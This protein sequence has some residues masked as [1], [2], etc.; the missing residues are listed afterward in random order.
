MRISKRQALSNYHSNF[1]MQLHFDSLVV[2]RE[3]RGPARLISTRSPARE[4]GSVDA[5]ENSRFA[6]DYSIAS[7]GRTRTRFT[8]S[9]FQNP[10]YDS[11][12]KTI[13]LPLSVVLHCSDFLPLSRRTPLPAAGR[14]RGRWLLRAHP[15]QETEPTATS[16]HAVF[17]SARLNPKSLKNVW[18]LTRQPHVV[19]DCRNQTAPLHDYKERISFSEAGNRTIEAAAMASSG[20]RR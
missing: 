13:F 12:S 15:H 2:W 5:A 11:E 4:L 8:P 19:C 3:N 20:G 7:I 16:N 14:W 9:I 6:G 17:P 10:A 18:G 1:T